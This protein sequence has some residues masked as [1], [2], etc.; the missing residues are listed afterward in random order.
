MGGILLRCFEFVFEIDYIP[1]EISLKKELY[2]LIANETLYHFVILKLWTFNNFL[3]N[4]L[5]NV[6]KPT[7]VI[8]MSVPI[9]FK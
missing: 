2:L 1:I 6:G 9:F 5:N 7:Y 8:H 4:V 3:T